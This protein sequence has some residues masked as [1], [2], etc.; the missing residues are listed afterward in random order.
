LKR[1]Y[2][3]GPPADW[4]SR[5][6]SANASSHPWEDW[7]ETWAHYLHM[8]DTI[9]TAAAFGMLLK[10]QH[11]AAKTMAA[12]PGQ[13]V[14]KRTDFDAIVETWLPLTYALN[15]LN[16]GMG[17]SDLYPFVLSSGAIEKLR[18]VHQVICAIETDAVTECEALTMGQAVG[19]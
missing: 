12:D 14:R 8:V 17:L 13:I 9:E 18:F 1:H 16:R 15:S 7:A 3:K 6:N 10:P 4:S 2:E 5:N 11:P 19:A